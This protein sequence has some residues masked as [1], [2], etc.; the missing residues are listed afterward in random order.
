MNIVNDLKNT[1]FKHIMKGVLYG[2]VFSLLAVLIFSLISYFLDFPVNIESTGLYIIL[3]ISLLIA[4][5]YVGKKAKGKGFLSGIIS[6]IL[7]ILLLLMFNV[8]ISEEQINILGFFKKV[9]LLLVVSFIGGVFGA[10]IR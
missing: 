7:V 6:G 2:G 1:S 10:N 5:I 3:N 8:L 4:S 9:P